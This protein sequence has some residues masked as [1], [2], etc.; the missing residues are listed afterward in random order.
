MKG[1]EEEQGGEGGKEERK[2]RQQ[3]GRDRER[4]GVELVLCHSL[5]G[6][7]SSEILLVVNPWFR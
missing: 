4:G 1:G 5:I 2:E 3:R 7:V 6:D